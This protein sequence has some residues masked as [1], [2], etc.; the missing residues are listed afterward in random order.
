M[1]SK[2]RQL[3]WRGWAVTDTDG[4]NTPEKKLKIINSVVTKIFK[5]FP[6]KRGKISRSNELVYN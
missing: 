1:D 4:I 2:T 3:V 6:R 5:N